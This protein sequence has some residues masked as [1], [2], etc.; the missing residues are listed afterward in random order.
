MLRKLLWIATAVVLLIGGALGSLY[1]ADIPNEEIRRLWADET[2]Q[3]PDI[4]GTEVHLR[5]QRPFDHPDAPVLVLL[6]G[7]ASS[8][9][10]W[11]GWVDRLGAAYRIVRFDLQGY[12]LTG[13][14]VDGDYSIGR[15]IR[16]GEALLDHL[17]I[18]SATLAGNSL[19]G[20]VAWRWA[21]AHPDR[22]ER[23]ILIDAA[24]IPMSALAT[25]DGETP[26]PARTAFSLGTMPVVK[27][28]ITRITPQFVVEDSLR[29]VYGD[30][31]KITPHLIQRH[32]DM[33]LAQG[34][35][36]AL[37]TAL[38]QRRDIP[39]EERQQWQR[40]VTI[41]QPSLILWGGNDHW[42]P[43]VL[44]TKFLELIPNS[45]IHVYPD[46]GHVPMEEAPEETASDVRAWL[47]AT[48]HEVMKQQDAPLE[49]SLPTSDQSERP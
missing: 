49:E 38:Q 21:L 12:G 35:R 48:Q 30:D 3:F 33:L 28:L 32:Y 11:D 36:R 37:Q 19:G 29:E 34:N 15:Q 45:E 1:R 10:T 7:T 44:G 25:D 9:H 13:P 43:V 27:H 41:Q 24:G 47:E 5:D 31:S 8:L 42:I 6:H 14:N 2:S 26:P 20:Y 17:G 23:L 4:L 22:V 46:A 18:A 39:L 16:V 40:L